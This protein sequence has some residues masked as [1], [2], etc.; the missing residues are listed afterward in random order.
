MADKRGA[1]DVRA[2]GQDASDIPITG[3][4]V[5]IGGRASDAVVTP[6]SADGDAVALWLSRR[7]AQFVASVP[8]IALDGSPYSLLTKTAQYTTTQTGTALWTP[9]AGKK[10]TVLSYQIQVGGTTA[11]TVQLWFESANPDTTYTRGTDQA[12]FDGE[13][14]PSST[15][16]PGVVQSGLWIGSAVDFD[17]RVTTSANI[18]PLTITVWGYE[19]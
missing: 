17:L 4:P 19:V 15:L 3:D 10:V 13:F 14:A 2:Q 8:H 12:I 9:A 1:S 16:K 18:N 7:G 5:L 11:G 6:V